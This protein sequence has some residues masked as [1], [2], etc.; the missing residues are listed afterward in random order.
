[1]KKT[2][3][4]LVLAVFTVPVTS[5][6]QCRVGTFVA[7]D[8]PGTYPCS[9]DADLIFND[10]GKEVNFT[11][12]STIQGITLEVFLSTDDRVDNAGGSH[13]KIS[14][15][16]LQDDNGGTDMGD[17]IT[18]DQAF[19]VPAGV[20]INDYQYVIIQCTSANVLW[21]RVQLGT[22]SS[23]CDPGI[24]SVVENDL[25][26]VSIFNDLDTDKAIIKNDLNLPLAISMYNI[27][28]QEL[29][30]KQQSNENSITLDLSSLSAGLYFMNVESQGRR[31][32]KKLLKK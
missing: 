16:Q 7:G 10:N 5:A 8:F 31:Q 23:T 32:I 18:N 14:T 11:N 9:G 12:F 19:I 21:G 17:A 30:N 13:I 6:Q 2:L 26:E 29:G 4:L 20:D 25:P 27:S 15:Q 3:L 1:M 28:G 22:V 24:L